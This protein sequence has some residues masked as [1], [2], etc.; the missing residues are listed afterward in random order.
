MFGKKRRDEIKLFI[1]QAQAERLLI[2]QQMNEDRQIISEQLGNLHKINDGSNI[3]GKPMDIVDKRKAAYALNLCTVSVSQ[4]IDYNDIYV[5]EQ[6]YEAILNNL[7]LEKIIKDEAL[8]NILKLLLDTISFFRIQEK[9]KEFIEKEYQNKLKN[10]IWNSVPN[11]SVILATANPY[12]AAAALATQVGIGYMNYRKNKNKAT[13]EKEKQMWELQ[14]SAIEQFNGIRRELF[15][16]SWRLAAKYEFPDEYRLTERQIHQYNQILMD[17]NDIRRY[18]RLNCIS[19]S[20]EAYPYFWY[21]LGNAANLISND[22][23]QF[24]E[25]TR[26]KYRDL[27][28]EHFNKFDE[29][30]KISVLREDQIAASCYLEYAELLDPVADRNKIIK[31]L[32]KAQKRCGEQCD[33]LQ[34]CAMN[35]LKVSDYDAAKRIMRKLVVENYNQKTNAQLLSF[36]YVNEIIL[37]SDEI[38]CKNYESLRYLVQPNESYLFPLPDNKN[39]PY[40]IAKLYSYSDAGQKENIITDTINKY[41]NKEK[42]LLIKN[43]NYIVQEIKDVYKLKFEKCFPVKKHKDDSYYYNENKIQRNVDLR[44]LILKED[45]FKGISD[46]I[47]F[48]D[49]II[50]LMRDLNNLLLTTPFQ[51]PDIITN[52]VYNESLNELVNCIYGTEKYHTQVII[53]SIENLRFEKLTDTYFQAFK[54]QYVRDIGEIE[55]F[56]HLSVLEIALLDFCRNNNI[57][58]EKSRAMQMVSDNEKFQLLIPKVLEESLKA[59]KSE[60]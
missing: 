41:I 29:M 53:E 58:I 1:E 48:P 47:G 30:D 24:D 43:W 12:A 4:I 6:E 42:S 31:L 9:E 3:Y 8:L 57:V 16:A 50:L 17:S 14:K 60:N 25:K 59:H 37:N 49:N 21:Y 26:I 10:A 35:Y 40:E 32:N 5:L 20:F 11:L 46:E 39:N 56:Y 27:A 23:T 52:I 33:V 13:D 7:N 22:S 18:E 51:V 54:E 44:K 34:I 36:I 38:S 2:A 45:K 55:D 15:D 28:I 19:E